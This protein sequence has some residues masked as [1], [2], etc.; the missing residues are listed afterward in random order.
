MAYTI[1][2]SYYNT[3]WL[4]KAIYLGTP[5]TGS[6]PYN[7]D[8]GGTDPD[9]GVTLPQQYR[10]GQGSNFPG[11]AWNP[12]G[13]PT[14]PSGCGSETQR[15]QTAPPTAI[16][17]TYPFDE[18]ENWFIEESRYQGGYNNVSTSFGAK[19]YLKEENNKQ[20]ARP[21]ALIYSGVY[22]SRTGLN[23]TNVFSV[24]EAITKAVD[25]QR[26]SIQKLYAEDTNLIVFQ[27][28]KVNRALIDKDQIYTSEGGTQ[29]LPQGTVIGQITPYRGEFGISKNPE[30]FAVYGFRKYF[31]DKDRGSILRLSHDGMTE[32][33][34]YGMSN[35]F[36]DELK[37]INENSEAVDVSAI[38]GNDQS[39]GTVFASPYI[40]ITTP[41]DIEI[42]SQLIINGIE[43]NSY[44]IGYDSNAA[45]ALSYV[46]LSEEISYIIPNDSPIIFRSFKKDRIVGGWDIHDGKYTLSLQKAKGTLS[47]GTSTYET[48]SFDEGVLGWPSFFSFKPNNLFSLKNT[49][50]TTSGGEIYQHYFNN[51]PKNR[52]VFYGAASAQ[53][54]ITFVFNPIPNTNKNFLT[55]GYEGS[56]GWQANSFIS[57]IQ[58]L[59]EVP[60]NYI[61]PGTTN[62]GYVNY[63]DTSVIVNS[64]YEGAYDS[65]GNEYPAALTEPIYRAG[66]HLKEGKYVANLKSNSTARAGEVVFGPDA[67][68]GYPTSGIKGYVA[69]VKI[70]TDSSTDIGGPKQIFAVF[71]NQVQSSN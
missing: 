1:E 17:Q 71:S 52:N 39:G 46:A 42:G 54:S 49:F 48:L 21:N 29:T 34:E 50:F 18:A 25:P 33:S 5:T 4:K 47:D 36:R 45:P 57:D 67:Y 44:V 55:V 3:F 40:T 20:E 15:Y 59:Q 51:N 27:E 31:A 8:A 58:G 53:S 22:N 16:I 6:I 69:T 11:L 70:S 38:Y 30:S 61:N 62:P 37:N 63:T 65:A 35:F 12:T 66:F 43:F 10:G 56:N 68:G 41:V 7:Y 19:A 14:Y 60:D 9:A 28:D 23:Q 32:I 26:G 64:Y 13:F 24:G 2:V